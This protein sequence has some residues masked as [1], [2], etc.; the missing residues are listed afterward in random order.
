[1]RTIANADKI[2]VKSK[3]LGLFISS[4]CIIRNQ[5]KN[6]IN[7]KSRIVAGYCWEW[8]S[9]GKNN[10]NIYDINIDKYD[11]NYDCIIQN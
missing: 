5:E 1:M 2:I 11:L 8:I 3:I 10:T 4:S 9:S 7:N 6:K